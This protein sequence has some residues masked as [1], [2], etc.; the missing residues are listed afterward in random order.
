MVSNSVEQHPTD[1]E[2]GT[3]KG[4]GQVWKYPGAAPAT[5]GQAVQACPDC[6]G[7]GRIQPIFLGTRRVGRPSPVDPGTLYAVAHQFYWDFRRL[8]EGRSKWFFDKN[9][10]KQLEKQV[11]EAELQLTDEQKVRAAEAAEEEIRSGSIQ[12]SE[13]ERRIR[14]IEESQLFATRA[15]LFHD[16]AEEA[17]RAV[18]VR[19]EP[20]VLEVLLD[21]NT[22]PEQIR[23]LCKDALM[24]RTVTLGSETREVEVPAWPIPVGS[25]FPIYLTEFA[26]DYVAALHD[27]RFPR[28]DVSQRPTN[29]LKQ[30]WF[31]SRALA[32]ALYGVTTRTAINLVGSLR[33]EQVF[34][35]SRRAKPAR[36]QRKLR[37]KS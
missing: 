12:E 22:T 16:A 25:T 1:T 34:E 33:P 23:E 28:C 13:R 11:Q 24:K 8:S 14:E 19:G 18:R 3:C 32:G 36:R 27:S 20:E 2:C 29:R 7:R 15:C 21:T 9:K 5:P 31:L 35:Q 30:F 17:R 4:N 6:N 26:E 37:T 10:H